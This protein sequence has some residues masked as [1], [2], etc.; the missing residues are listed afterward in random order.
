MSAPPSLYAKRPDVTP[1][2]EQV[3]FRALA[4]HPDQRVPS[5][6]AFANAL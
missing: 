1:D 2:V 3:I 6:G 4:K 5:V